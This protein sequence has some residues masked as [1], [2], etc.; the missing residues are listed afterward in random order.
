MRI[1]MVDDNIDFLLATA[2]LLAA[3]GF[4]SVETA[5]SERDAL[6][7]LARGDVDVVL[8]DVGLVEGGPVALAAALADDRIPFALVSGDDRRLALPEPL[9]SAPLL[10]K[11]VEQGTLLELLET[12]RRRGD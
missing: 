8:L 6:R 9:R 10:L 7:E 1:L 4:P 2:E 11:P 12:I 5:T 3:C